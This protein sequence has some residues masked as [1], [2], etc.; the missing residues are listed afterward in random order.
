M[1]FSAGTDRNAAFCQ[2]IFDKLKVNRR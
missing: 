1:E 2:Q